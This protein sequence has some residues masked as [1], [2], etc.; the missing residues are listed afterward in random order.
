EELVTELLTIGRLEQGERQLA[1]MQ[2]KVEELNDSVAASVALEIADRRLTLDVS[3]RGGRACHVC[4]AKLVARA[5]LNLF[6]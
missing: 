4:D 5:V 3:V 1:L 6:R 2:V